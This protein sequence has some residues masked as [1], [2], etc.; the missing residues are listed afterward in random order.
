MTLTKKLNLGFLVAFFGGAGVFITAWAAIWLARG[1]FL[2][3]IVALGFALLSFGFSFQM[4]YVFAAAPRPRT[5]WGTD[6]TVVRTSRSVDMVFGV[7]H[8]AGFCTAALYLAFAP[9]N[10][11]DWEPPRVLRFAVPAFCVFLLLFGAPTLYRAFKHGGES[12]LRLDPNGFEVWNGSWGLEKR[13]SWEDVE[14]ILDHPVRGR[15]IRRDMIV[16]VLPKGRSA[17]LVTDAITNDSHALR[18]WV[19]FYWKHPQYRDELTDGR[20]LQRLGQEFVAE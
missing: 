11:I 12:H 20:A 7:S 18:E 14:E 17:M 8:V 3:G 1:S 6:G 10:V 2:T 19:R 15:K 9:F 4:G 13:G 16:F 5:H